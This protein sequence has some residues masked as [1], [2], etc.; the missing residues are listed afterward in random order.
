MS[1]LDISTTILHKEFTILYKSK[2]SI[3]FN[4]AFN[5]EYNSTNGI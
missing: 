5:I 4:A 2:S 3:T 1:L